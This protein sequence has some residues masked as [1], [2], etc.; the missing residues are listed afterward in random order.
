MEQWVD[1]KGYEDLYA[2]NHLGQVL[3]KKRGII[4]KG[5][6]STVYTTYSLHKNNKRSIALGHR[7]V[8]LAFIKNPMNKPQVNHKDGNKRNNNVENLEWVTSSEN[9]L[10]A[11]R[12]GLSSVSDYN[13]AIVSKLNSGALSYNSK[14]VKDIESGEIYDTLI[15]ASKATNISKSTLHRWAHKNKRFQLL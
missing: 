9:C 5:N 11:Y 13:K 7:L 2:V 3:S 15:A 10:H 8:A 6:Y 14:K 12:I 4:L 1:I